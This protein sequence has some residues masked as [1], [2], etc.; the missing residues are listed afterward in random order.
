M[1][2][3]GRLLS[4]CGR[5]SNRSV[6]DE[7]AL[8][9]LLA[10]WFEAGDTGALRAAFDALWAALP[11]PRD[12]CRRLGRDEVEG[13]LLEELEVLLRREGGELRHARDPF[14]FAL[15]HVQFRLLDRLRKERRR[16]RLA[17]TVA[18]DP[19]WEHSGA[20][21]VGPDA[22]GVDLLRALAAALD[23]MTIDRRVAFL[24]RHAPERISDVDWSVVMRRHPPPPPTR[25]EMPPGDDAAALLLNPGASVDAYRKNLQ[26]ALDDLAA[27]LLE[28]R[29]R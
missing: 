28:G 15:K 13:I 12:V 19:C 1:T 3:R 29:R 20:A 2:V 11:R 9:D 18:L 7:Q 26:R 17:P 22:E 8:R 25:P 10:R 23:A 21:S 27:V 5:A 14:A 4:G 16:E 6:Q 24:L